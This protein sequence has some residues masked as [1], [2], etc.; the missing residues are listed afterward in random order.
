MARRAG[1][2][3]H[4]FVNGSR[5]LPPRHAAGRWLD[6]ADH[7]IW[8]G[9]YRP[10]IRRRAARPNNPRPSTAADAGSLGLPGAKI[11][12]GADRRDDGATFKIAGEGGED[13]GKPDTRG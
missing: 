6:I 10:R 2:L 4:N 1:K 13:G 8:G 9:D 12:N 3:N 5:R 11:G 7:R